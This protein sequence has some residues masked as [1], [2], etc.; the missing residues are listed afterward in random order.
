M[1]MFTEKMVAPCG[2]DCSLCR[3]AHE[4]ENAC[5]GCL[6]PDENKPEFCSARCDIIRCEKRKKFQYR[7]CDECPEFPCEYT[8]EREN[9]Y[10]SKYVLT[11][12]PFE[13]LEMIRKEGMEKFLHR[14]KDLWTCKSCGGVISVHN[15]I[16]S[17]CGK[18]YGREDLEAKQ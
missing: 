1:G 5:P 16:C 8:T 7:F 10:R 3:R 18:Q 6:G 13:N 9:R 2:L 11:E 12:S 14:Q 4:A 17:Q 15:G